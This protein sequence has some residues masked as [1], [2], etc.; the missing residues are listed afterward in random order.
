MQA[1]SAILFVSWCQ[2]S[3]T[4]DNSWQLVS[5]SARWLILVLRIDLPTH[6][7]ENETTTPP[8]C[9]AE[10]IKMLTVTLKVVKQA[11]AIR[12]LAGGL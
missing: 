3:C 10:S 1:T 4:L 9:F 5:E 2:G 6:T 7:I 12:G 11:H 8:R